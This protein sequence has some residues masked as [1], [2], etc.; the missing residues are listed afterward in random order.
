MPEVLHIAQNYRLAPD[1][2]PEVVK[3][4]VTLRMDTNFASFECLT[5]ILLYCLCSVE[6]R[7][8]PLS[9]GC[10]NRVFYPGVSQ[11]VD[12]IPLLGLDGWL[13]GR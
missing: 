5:G 8:C 1:I 7:S 12:R 4:E 13:S 2:L 11:A 6:K 10:P 3:C 9:A